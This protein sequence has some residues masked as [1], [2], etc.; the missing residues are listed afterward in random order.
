MAKVGSEKRVPTRQ[1]I[2]TVL[3]SFKSQK[4]DKAARNKDREGLIRQKFA[5]LA[6]PDLDKILGDLSSYPQWQ[7]GEINAGREA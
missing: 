1:E 2:E 6:T 3:A 4:K 7:Q 5:H